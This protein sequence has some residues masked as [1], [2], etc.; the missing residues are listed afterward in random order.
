[1]SA[2]VRRRLAL[3]PELV[4]RVAGHVEDTGPDPELAYHSG[5]D[6]AEVTRGLLAEVP[7]DECLIAYGSLIWH[8]ACAVAATRQGLALGW[9]RAFRLKL[10]RSSGSREQPG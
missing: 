5:A 4:A 2:G 1:M 10:T 7:P 3:T 9:H 6:Y 8:P